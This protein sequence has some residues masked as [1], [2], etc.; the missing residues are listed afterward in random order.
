MRCKGLTALLIGLFTYCS[1]FAQSGRLRLL[2]VGDSAT[3]FTVNIYE[4]NRLRV[5]RSAE[6]SLELSNLDLSITTKLDWKGTSWSGND[7]IVELLHNVYV[8]AFDADLQAVVRY[9]VM[10]R[11][12]KKTVRLF[13]PSMPDMYYILR[14]KDLPAEP[15]SKYISFE[16]DSFPGGFVHE[17]FPAVGWVTPDNQTVG[18]LTDAG[19]LNQYSRATRRRF[20][21]REGGLTG[22][23]KLP[24]P[25]LFVLPGMDERNHGNAFV[26]QTYGEMYNLDGGSSRSL[27]ITAPFLPQGN[28]V[29]EQKETTIS[30]TGSGKG[31]GISFFAPM[32]GQHVYTISFLS[33]GNAPVSLKFWRMKNGVQT[34]ELED[35]LKYIDGFKLNEAAWTLFKGSLLV[36]YIGGDSIQ[37]LL[38]TQSTQASS[39]Q[40]KDLRIEEQLPARE[41]YNILPLGKEM[42]KTSFV[43]I[44][45]WV[46]QKDFMISAQTRLAEGKSFR[47]SQIE[48]MMYGNFN[49]LT[50][51]TSVNDFT[52]FNVP[53]M[54]YMPDMYN[55]DCFFAAVS[56]YNKELNI[57]LWN[58]WTKTQ[59]ARGAIG[60]I[61][62]PMMGSVEAKDN[63]ASIEWLIWAMLN[64]LRFGYNAPADKIKR[65]V[66]YVLNEFDSAGTGICYSHFPLCQID[67]IDFNPKTNRLA[68]NQ[69]MLAI[70]LRTIRE[71]GYPVSDD[72]L[73]KAEQAY[74]DFYDPQRKHLLYDRNFPDLICL[75]DLEPEFFSLWLFKR[76]LLTDEIVQNELNLIPALNKVSNSPHPEMGTT[77]PVLIRLIKNKPGYAF[78]SAGYQPFEKFGVENYANGKNDGYYYNGGSWLRPEYCAYVAGMKHGWAPARS[79]MENRVWAEI[80]LNPQWPFS[81]EFIPTKWKSFD[82]WWPSTKGLCWN[83]FILMAD[84]VAGMRTPEMDPDFKSN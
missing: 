74:R 4:G 55:R 9:Q 20:S 28:T 84:E 80:N 71:L 12:V 14:E 29:I 25:E 63:E 46:S 50:W 83:I 79:R 75:S 57:T 19:Y 49:M 51:I 73:Q 61:I 47:G 26:Q 54:N 22:I 36:P 2:V 76:P 48:K 24:D 56:T 8:P 10:D 3:G 33:K 31:Q 37:I 23:R 7:S 27:K 66:D 81:K 30:L 34:V 65:T 72:H 53:N 52:P 70:A 60:T 1:S 18:F 62:T 15:P 21:G 13:Q 40:I 69:G 78:L 16:Y 35:G 43:F 38:G 59:T 32:S 41:P 5:S 45:P 44:E 77:A 11:V 58:Q 67:I 6:F 39:I 82:A 68:V 42:T 64:K 17:M